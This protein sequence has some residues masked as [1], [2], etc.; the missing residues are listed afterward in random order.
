[1][2]STLKR[3]GAFASIV[4]VIVC[5]I[6]ITGSTFSL[7]TGGD[8]GDVIIDAANVEVSVSIG[9]LKLYSK[10]VEQL[11]TKFQNGGIADA[12]DLANG[13]LVLTNMSPM[14]RITFTVDVTNES[15]IDTVYRV[16][17]S[18]NGE[19][20]EAL[21]VQ[22]AGAPSNFGVTDWIPLAAASSENG[23]KFSAIVVSVEFPNGDADKWIPEGTGDNVYENTSCTIDIAVEAVQGNA[24]V[25]NPVTYDAATNT[26][27]INSEE[28][29]A[30]MDE[31][32]AKGANVAVKVSD[33]AAFNDA[34][35]S[36]VSKIIVT[37]T[38]SDSAIKL[39]SNVNSLTIS[40]GTFVNSPINAADGNS[41]S[42]KNLT[43][44]GVTFENS[45]ILLTGW[46]N[47]EETIENLTVTN[48]TFK[49][50]N[51]DTNTAPV[52]I[53]KDAAE[54]VVNFT[55]T[56]NVIDGAT[57]GSKSGIYVQA[58]GKVVVADN[59]IN[60]VSFRPFVIQ[61]TNDD[62]IADEL[63]VT[64]NTFSGSAVGRL[65][66]LGSN[67]AGTDTVVLK[68]N[69]NIITGVTGA[70]QICYW[71]F[72]PEKTTID[73]SCNYYDID[74]VENPSRIYY[75]GSA[76][77]V[78]DLIKMTVYPFYAELNEDGTIN[79]DSLVNAPHN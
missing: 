59:I 28:G 35:A 24:D 45:R 44:D 22:T 19:L 3:F 20:A 33:A 23:D 12:T 67:E 38:I 57:G 14:D 32:I 62:G 39:P 30:M 75:N 6:L 5:V 1:M 65:Q 31:I 78:D 36:G 71:N 25:V 10:G 55:F 9:N 60:N 40:G 50:L 72:N 43:F 76:A 77:G 15:T 73:F 49:N 18:A 2:Q 61:I 52:H 51:D 70:Q 42:Y 54:A 26:Y 79:T 8:N 64:G 63:I 27:T 53:N 56:N 47:G 37:G 48:C 4:T 74:I 69:N 41:Y 7:F 16:K 13:K 58:T 11:G 34:L 46:R 29:E 21:V 17:I 68:I 66:G